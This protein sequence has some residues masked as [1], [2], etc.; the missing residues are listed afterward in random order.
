MYVSTAKPKTKL[1]SDSLFSDIAENIPEFGTGFWHL[2]WDSNGRFIATLKDKGALPPKI[3]PASAYESRQNQMIDS[4]LTT[5]P[6]YLIEAISDG[7]KDSYY[8][9]FILVELDRMARALGEKI[10]KLLHVRHSSKAHHRY[11]NRGHISTSIRG[12]AT[13]LGFSH[14]CVRR[15]L[16]WLQA[17]GHAD[18]ATWTVR[19]L[20]AG[21]CGTIYLKRKAKY[22]LRKIRRARGGVPMQTYDDASA[23]IG[24]TGNVILAMLAR[25]FDAD[26]ICAALNLTAKNFRDYW[27]FK[28]RWCG[29]IDKAL[30]LLDVAR[31]KVA[32]SLGT[33]GVIR[34]RRDRMEAEQSRYVETA[35]ERKERRF[36]KRRP[37]SDTARYSTQTITQSAPASPAVALPVS[38]NPRGL[39]SPQAPSPHPL[40]PMAHTLRV[41]QDPRSLLPG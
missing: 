3:I 6:I 36:Q 33:V 40:N 37:N 1:E 34:K 20:D 2:W 31:D 25:G 4:E 28:L 19:T 23:G 18:R 7:S 9:C 8:A 39:L 27:V 15:G 30:N 14:G 11:G 29:L 38:E 21:Y 35:G 13:T 12:L 17:N 5:D 10:E 26:R 24:I 16:I 32:K 22:H 41:I